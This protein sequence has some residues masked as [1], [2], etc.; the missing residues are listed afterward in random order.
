MSGGP[1]VCLAERWVG[2]RIDNRKW[3]ITDPATGTAWTVDVNS[4]RLAAEVV[5]NAS[6]TARM[7]S[8][9][10]WN[11]APDKLELGSSIKKSFFWEAE[12]KL[13]DVA[14]IDNA[15]FMIGLCD[16]NNTKRSTVNDF[17]GFGLSDSEWST[18]VIEDGGPPLE[19]AYPSYTPTDYNKLSYLI[20]NGNVLF[21]INGTYLETVDISAIAGPLYFV[22]YIENNVGGA[23]TYYMSEL[24]GIP[25][26]SPVTDNY[27][28]NPTPLF[29]KKATD[30][31]FLIKLVSRF[32]TREIVTGRLFGDISVT[33]AADTDSSLSTY[34]VLTADW[35]EIGE[36]WYSLNIGAS[37][38]ASNNT[39]YEVT[40]KDS[41]NYFADY[42][43]QV[44]VTDL[45]MDEWQ[46]Y[47]GTGASSTYNI[48][49]SMEDNRIYN[50]NNLSGLKDNR[51]LIVKTKNSVTSILNKIK[52]GL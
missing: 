48:T 3:I 29:A 49:K 50:A 24:N 35:V 14:N 44:H 13:V 36:G 15:E 7:S 22:Y 34:T 21:W 41:L 2:E 1:L 11:V 26:D 6:E 18:L 33:Y 42:T 37:E 25:D 27:L 43:F 47:V 38:F 39:V 51:N 10:R 28:N 30:K 32:N 31:T 12:I 4:G 19:T 17:I 40:V 9:Q 20:I 52:R 23:S 46:D 5:L 16:A 8:K 45:T